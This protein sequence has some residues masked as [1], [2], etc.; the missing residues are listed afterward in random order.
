[1]RRCLSSRV[2]FILYSSDQNLPGPGTSSK[3]CLKT[4]KKS[5]ISSKA[6]DPHLHALIAPKGHFRRAAGIASMVSG[7]PSIRIHYAAGRAGWRTVPLPTVL[8]HSLLFPTFL[9][10]NGGNS[11]PFPEIHS[12]SR[13][14]HS[15]PFLW[16]K[17]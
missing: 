4:K 3:S 6:F 12:H 8:P 11:R 13:P 7:C 10:G 15:R 16:R 9:V 5:L 17:N 1:M 2:I 14:F